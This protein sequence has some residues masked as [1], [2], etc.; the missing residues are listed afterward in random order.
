MKERVELAN[1]RLLV[2]PVIP[3]I[4]KLQRRYRRLKDREKMKAAIFK[5]V[6]IGRMFRCLRRVNQKTHFLDLR[7]RVDRMS[8]INNYSMKERVKGRERRLARIL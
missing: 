2:E 5:L 7:Y 8:M 3:I 4:I 1:H 6:K